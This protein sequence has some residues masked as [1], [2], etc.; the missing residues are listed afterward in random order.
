[1][2]TAEAL[3]KEHGTCLIPLE[4]VSATLFNLSPDEARHYINSGKLR[5]KTTR[6]RNSQKA[7]ILLHVDDLADYID[8]VRAKE[9]ADHE[10]INPPN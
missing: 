2:N 8:G 4:K 3:F 10:K 1:M 5:I 9:S 7:P 6:L